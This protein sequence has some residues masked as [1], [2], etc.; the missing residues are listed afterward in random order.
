MIDPHPGIDDGIVFDLGE[1]THITLRMNLN[2]FADY[3]TGADIG[4]CTD[5]GVFADFSGRINEARL[6]NTF[7]GRNGLGIKFKQG[8]ESI[9]GIIHPELKVQPIFPLI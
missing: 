5:I 6:L 1:I 2:V 3:H 4:E 7:F 9:I 8:S